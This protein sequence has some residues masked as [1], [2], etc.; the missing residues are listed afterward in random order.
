MRKETRRSPT[1]HSRRRPTSATVTIGEADTITIDGAVRVNIQTTVSM[2]QSA[3]DINGVEQCQDD[4]DGVM[5]QI[6]IMILKEIR[7]Y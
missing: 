2:G 5:E 6:M 3:E 1:L 7:E 4:A